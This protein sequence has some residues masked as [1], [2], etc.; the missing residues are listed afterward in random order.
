MRIA[1][2]LQQ[3]PSTLARLIK[4]YP[5][6]SYNCDKLAE[7]ISDAFKAAGANPQIITI[8]DKH[9]A[10]YFY[11]DKYIQ[12]AKTGFHQ[13]VKV[14]DRVYDALTGPAGMQ[15]AQYVNMLK[16][17]GIIPKIK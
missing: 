13:A 2:K 7:K 12:F 10:P 5:A 14:G 15:M 17:Y 1:S 16:S 9:G 11:T 4:R 6:S 3:L 8:T